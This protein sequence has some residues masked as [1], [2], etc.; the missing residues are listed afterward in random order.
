MVTVIDLA[1][2]LTGSWEL[3]VIAVSN[4]QEAL[5][6]KNVSVAQGKLM[7]LEFVK[8]VEHTKELK[9]VTQD[10]HQTLAFQTRKLCL[11]VH[12]KHVRSILR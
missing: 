6:L 9:T 11:M 8:N 2:R 5:S 3:D 12:A 1:P 10:V 4:L 7:F